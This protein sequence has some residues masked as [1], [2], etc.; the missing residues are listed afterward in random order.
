MKKF[1]IYSI[2]V[3][4]LLTYSFG[5]YAQ[6]IGTSP[7]KIPMLLSANFGELRNNHFHSGIDVKIQGKIGTPLYSFDDGY[8][9]RIFVS[10]SGYG[11][12][13]YITHP[14]GYTTVYGHM[15]GF[16]DEAAEYVKEYQY[17]NETF[18]ADLY[19]PENKISVKKGQYI[20]RGGNTGSSGGPHLHFE[21]R[22][23]KTEEALNPLPFMERYL[24]DNRS[25][26][27]QEIMVMP[28]NNNG[29]VN[30]SSYKK[31]F[32]LATNKKTGKK[33][34][35]STITAWGE[36]GVAVKAYDYMDKVSN[37]FGPYEITLQVDGNQIFGSKIDNFAFGETRYLNSFIDYEDWRRNNSFFMK[38][39]V[40][41]GNKL[42][43]YHNLVNRGVINIDEERDYN[44]TYTL[45]DYFGNKTTFNFTVSGSPETIRQPE[46]RD[47]Y[48]MSYNKHNRYADNTIEF[49]IPE[50]NLYTDISFKYGI[51]NSMEYL[52]PIYTLHVYE[53][54]PLHGYC[55]L[56]I[57]VGENQI[58]DVSKCYIARI[59]K[60]GR[61]LYSKSEYKNGWFETQ[62]RDFGDYAVVSDFT[63]PA[64]T[65]QLPG[66]WGVN[67]KINCKISDR[68][69]GIKTYKAEVDGKFFLLEYD[70]KNSL[71]SAALDPSR[72]QKGGNH[73]FRLVVTDNCGNESEYTTEFIW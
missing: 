19:L 55:S 69:S 3:G 16:F 9:S 70:A 28:V 67:D 36:I 30:G 52:S 1:K 24:T 5:I 61:A 20:G 48:R 27:I 12:A 10:P 59:N 39:F 26:Q 21:V 65:P 7:V 32:P 46:E 51:R 31:R 13:L 56:K 71:L 25:P 14:N 44:L 29:M 63:P 60:N 34:I 73:A 49:D 54:D 18:F 41:P 17:E 68:H 43:L 2:I 47:T 53:S 33:S 50:G 8:I 6:T 72:I 38:S 4:L 40:D 37:I 45:S 66:K 35:N 62:I 57:K 23:T 11:K 42:R 22:D 58:P 15:D 64:I